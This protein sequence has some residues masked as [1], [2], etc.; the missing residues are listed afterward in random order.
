M[1]F[2]IDIC[3]I[4]KDCET[5]LENKIKEEKTDKKKNQ[6]KRIKILKENEPELIC[7]KKRPKFN[8]CINNIIKKSEIEDDLIIRIDN[9]NNISNSDLDLSNSI[10]RVKEKEKEEKI[11]NEFNSARAEFCLKHKLY[12]ILMEQ[13]NLNVY[14]PNIYKIKDDYN[15]FIYPDELITYFISQSGFLTKNENLKNNLIINDYNNSK[16]NSSLGLYFCGEC[17]IL[18]NG[19]TAKK[20]APNEFICKKC[21]EINKKLYNIKNK[22]LINING[23]VAKMNKG[24]YHCF[25]HFL[26][27]NQIEDCITRFS[28]KAC[29]LL[30]TNSN[31]FF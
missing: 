31:Y 20:C 5:E 22:Y 24:K 30:N 2:S 9:N 4:N 6:E 1:N 8:I 26:V 12:D 3:Q 16:Y 27:K 25:G 19:N 29:E 21:M 28:C 14:V 13:N 15:A 10:L 11:Q 17:I 23:R 18:E 7:I